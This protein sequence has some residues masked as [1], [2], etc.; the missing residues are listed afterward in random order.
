MVADPLTGVVGSW[1][2]PGVGGEPICAVEGGEVSYRDEKLHAQQQTH[3]GKAEE[4]LGEGMVEEAAFELLVD[5]CCAFSEHEHLGG[6]VGDDASGDSFSGQTNA[7]CLCCGD[8][9]LGERCGSP[10]TACFQVCLDTRPARATDGFGTLV[11]RDQHERA[12]VVEVQD[13]FEPWEKGEQGLSEP[14]YGT[15]TGDDEVSAVGDQQP[16]FCEDFFNRFEHGEIASHPGLLGD[17]PRITSIGLASNF[18]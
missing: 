6:E 18:C 5:L 15:G 10:Y 11:A 3:A 7:P 13:A 9:L 14:G 12:L 16:Q 2:E 8:D 17:E 1:H 4:D